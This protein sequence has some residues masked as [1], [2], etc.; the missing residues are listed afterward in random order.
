MRMLDIIDKKRRKEA[1]TAEEIAFFTEGFT[2]GKIP[3]YQ[4]SALLMAICLNG[5]TE[6]ETAVLTDCMSHSGDMLDLSDLGDTTADKHST[7]G[8]GDKTTLIVAP[9]CAAAGVKIAKMSGRGL[10]HTGGTVDKLESIPGFQVA[11][12]EAQFKTQVQKI[13]LAV[14]GQT[15]NLAPADKKLYALRDASGTVNSIPLIASSI[16]SK[17]LA[18]GAQN[19][20]LDVKCGSGAFMQ[21]VSDARALAKEMVEIGKH[22][23]R[24]TAAVITNM[25]VP[26]GTHIGNALEVTEAC[27]ILRG[28]GDKDLRELCLILSAHLISMSL[29]VPYDKAYSDAERLLSSGAAYGKLCEMVSAQGGDR[30]VLESTDCFLQ[31]GCTHTVNAPKNGYIAHMQTKTIGESASL[32]GAGRETKESAIDYAAGIVLKKKTGDFVKCGEPIAVLYAANAERCIAGE[33][34]FA[35]SL[36]FSDTPPKTQPLILGTVE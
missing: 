11:L 22:C 18:A 17:K 6:K 10:G 34:R 31:A 26:L 32:L 33:Q 15:A 5:M 21:T 8:V 28:T 2:N 4:A 16:M 14:T 9:I 27:G 7:G 20:A 19:I 30:S 29:K 12:T 13:G 23:G 1:L 3:D 25:D 36:T 35:E 24:N